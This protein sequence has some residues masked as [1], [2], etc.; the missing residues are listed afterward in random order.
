MFAKHKYAYYMCSTYAVMPQLHRHPAETDPKKMIAKHYQAANKLYGGVGAGDSSDLGCQDLPKQ[1]SSQDAPP[2]A[3][4]TPVAPSANGPSATVAASSAVAGS[5]GLASS[6]ASASSS[7]PASPSASPV[8]YVLDDRGRRKMCKALSTHTGKHSPC[9]NYALAG[10]YGYCGKHRE[11]K[12]QR[13]KS[14]VVP[15]GQRA[16]IGTERSAGRS[17]G[18]V[19]KSGVP[20]DRAGGSFAGGS[21]GSVATGTGACNTVDTSSAPSDSTEEVIVMEGVYKGAD[22][23][24]V[25]INVAD[26]RASASLHACECVRMCE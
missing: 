14:P 21:G 3:L 8:G 1:A 11:R 20:A 5:T 23:D 22:D 18:A 9:G 17:G 12:R 7:A 26:A 19:E 2:P 15:A 6:P 13:E 4:Q 24:K 16:G 10:N 25:P